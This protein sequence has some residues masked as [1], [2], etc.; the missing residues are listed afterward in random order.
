[1]NG[2]P[3]LVTFPT[4]SN[5]LKMEFVDLSSGHHKMSTQH[6]F[7]YRGFFLHCDPMPM[8]D[9]RYGAQVVVANDE[10]ASHLERMFPAL[11][12]FNTEADAVAFAKA[13]GVQWVDNEL[14]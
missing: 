9:G 3:I 12:Y 6:G 13:Y 5:G 4:G 14:D 10:G 11:E 2:Y 1:M 8:G 7:K